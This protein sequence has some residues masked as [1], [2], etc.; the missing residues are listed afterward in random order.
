[1]PAK[2]IGRQ[3]TI[4]RSMAIESGSPEMRGTPGLRDSPG[5]SIDSNEEFDTIISKLNPSIIKNAKRLKRLRLEASMLQKASE[6]FAI[7]LDGA[8]RSSKGFTTLNT[9]R[10]GHASSLNSIRS[11]S[12][13][14]RQGFLRPKEN[15]DWVKR[16]KESYVSSIKLH[17]L[18]EEEDMPKTKLKINWEK[19]ESAEF[20]LPR[21][22]AKPGTIQRR[23]A[24]FDEHVKNTRPQ[25]EQ[26]I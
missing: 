25:R 21:S 17:K 19:I 24:I 6:K 11:G 4:Y 15:K 7:N 18:Q 22:S 13:D 2:K 12:T 10:A 16:N 9:R 5:L 26:V 3:G 14:S 23:M 1:M 20:N 8:K